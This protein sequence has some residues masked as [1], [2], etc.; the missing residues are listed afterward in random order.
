LVE[1][2]NRHSGATQLV[3][4]VLMPGEAE[5]LIATPLKIQVTDELLA[6]V[7]QLFGAPVCE[8]G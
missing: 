2:A 5:V 1:L 7:D 4:Q 8:L 3:I 6:A